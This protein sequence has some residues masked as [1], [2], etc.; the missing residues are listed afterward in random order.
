MGIPGSHVNTH[1]RVPTRKKVLDDTLNRMIWPTDVGPSLAAPKLA[2]GLWIQWPWGQRQRLWVLHEMRPTA[3]VPCHQGRWSYCHSWRP[4]GSRAEHADIAPL[5]HEQLAIWWQIKRTELPFWRGA[6]ISPC[7]HFRFRFSVPFSATSTTIWDF[8][9]C[10]IFHTTLPQSQGAG[11]GKRGAARSKRQWDALVLLCAYH[12]ETS[13]V[14]VRYSVN[15]SVHTSST[16][17][18][19]SIYHFPFKRSGES[20]KNHLFQDWSR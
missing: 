19:V 12:L 7:A 20:W 10:L 9:D 16:Q 17:I 4:K 3:R 11:Y 18:T 6:D 15:D 5:L 14:T 13:T 8:T 2:M 1:W